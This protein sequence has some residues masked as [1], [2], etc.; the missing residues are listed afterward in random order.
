MLPTSSWESLIFMNS[1]VILFLLAQ[2]VGSGSGAASCPFAIKEV[3]LP[4]S[5]PRI[6]VVNMKGEALAPGRPG[7]NLE[8]ARLSLHVPIMLN[9]AAK[10]WIPTDISQAAVGL[11]VALPKDFYARLLRGYGGEKRKWVASDDLAVSERWDDLV[12]F[13]SEIWGAEWSGGKD[14]YEQVRALI[15]YSAHVAVRVPNGC[16]IKE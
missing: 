9:A 7:R 3:T 2:F 6:S 1:K 16:D 15:S 12:S 8:F 4:I 11:K 14:P 5:E 13:L 10:Y